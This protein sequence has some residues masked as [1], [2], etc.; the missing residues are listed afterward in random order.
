[1]DC[2][3]VG[4]DRVARNGDVANKIGTYTHAVLARHHGIPFFVAAPRST[5]DPNTPSGQNIPIEERASEEVTQLFGRSIV[6]EGVTAR[7]P[8]FD[9]TP[10]ELVSAL[11][12]E[13]GVVHAPSWD[14]LTPFMTKG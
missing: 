10:A 12:T 13:E 8:A 9:I 5:L 3:I 6:P 14:N 11:I 2:V 4:A 7:H 1:V